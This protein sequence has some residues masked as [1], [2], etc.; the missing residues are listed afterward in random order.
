MQ[1]AIGNLGGYNGPKFFGVLK[2]MTGN[3]HA[4]FYFLAASLVLAAIMT[5]I[6]ERFIKSNDDIKSKLTNQPSAS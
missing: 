1:N 5:L 3:Y 6:L 2:D 4:G